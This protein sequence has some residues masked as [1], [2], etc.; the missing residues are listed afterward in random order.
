MISFQTTSAVYFRKPEF[1]PNKRPKCMIL[2]IVTIK[3]VIM[4]SQHKFKDLL[5]Q[6]IFLWMNILY[7]Q[8]NTPRYG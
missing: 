1:K 7:N 6:Q 4:I 2:K 3:H 8:A 5:V